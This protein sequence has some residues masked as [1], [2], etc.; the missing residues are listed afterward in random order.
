MYVRRSSVIATQHTHGST[1][2]SSHD[3]SSHAMGVGVGSQVAA[4]LQAKKRTQA[5]LCLRHHVLGPSVLRRPPRCFGR[6][7]RLRQQ[8][9]T[10]TAAR[11]RRRGPVRPWLSA[12]CARGGVVAVAQSCGPSERSRTCTGREPLH[13]ARRLGPCGRPYLHSQ[14]LQLTVAAAASAPATQ[15]SRDD[16]STPR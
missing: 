10:C 14:S 6:C 16:V 5:A 4:L 3:A 15:C 8:A 12:L 11:P 2:H 1:E 13:R 7:D 9:L